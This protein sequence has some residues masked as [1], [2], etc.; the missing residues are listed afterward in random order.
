MSDSIKKL[1]DTFEAQLRKDRAIWQELADLGDETAIERLE[2]ENVKEALK[3]INS[4][5]KKKPRSLV[6]RDD[7]RQLHAELHSELRFL[8][9]IVWVTCAVQLANLILLVW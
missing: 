7:L 4:P 6:T 9:W 2:S 3:V 1:L 8:L 5:P